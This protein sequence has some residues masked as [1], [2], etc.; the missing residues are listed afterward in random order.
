MKKIKIHVEAGGSVEVALTGNYFRALTAADGFNIDFLNGVKTDFL[1]GLGM[2]VSAFERIRIYSDTAQDITFIAGTGQV[3]DSRLAGQIDLNGA[4]EMLQSG[5][6]TNNYG[7]VSVGT[8]ATLIIPA[9]ASRRAYL[10]Q[11][12]GA[13][14]VYIGSTSGLTLANGVKLSPAGSYSAENIKAVYAISGVAGQD[15]RFSEDVN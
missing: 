3:D 9:N 10:L 13:D 15:L 14:D 12:L 5:A 7:A 2:R 11:H 4:L 6:T 8:V 1:A